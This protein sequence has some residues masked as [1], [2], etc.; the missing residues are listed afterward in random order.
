MIPKNGTIN[1]GYLD[2]DRAGVIIDKYPVE[3]HYPQFTYVS[4]AHLLDDPNLVE[5]I[6]Q[7][8]E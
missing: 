5:I 2:I 4:F 6:D 8:D 3:K 1:N 7:K